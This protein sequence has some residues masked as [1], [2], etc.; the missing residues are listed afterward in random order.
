GAAFS[1]RLPLMV[2]RTDGLDRRHPTVQHAEASDLQRL[3]GL[4][5]LVVDDEPDASD[6]VEELLA[7]CGAET[8]AASSAEEAR[9]ILAGW[10]PDVLL[11]DVGMPEED[12]YAFI[13]SL[14]AV[15]TERRQIP[16]VALTA[17]ASR[18]DKV[19]LLSAGFQAH[20]PKPVDTAEL[21][22]VVASIARSAGKLG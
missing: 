16:A 22:A 6:A 5:V 9:S 17:Y 14:R 18:D 21:V 19:R 12:G 20:V 2:A 15:A 10:S 8:R 4:R 7:A 3:D 11:S 1:V 13:A